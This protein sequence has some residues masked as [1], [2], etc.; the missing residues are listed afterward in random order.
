MSDFSNIDPQSMATQLAGFDVQTLQNQL[1]TQKSKL[2]SQQT[3]LRTL[4][5]ALTEFRTS[6]QNLNKTNAGMLKTSSSV[7]VE[8]M[9]KVTTTSETRKGTYNVFVEQLASSHQLAYNALDEDAVKNATG[10]MKIQVGS[11]SSK[12]ITVDMDN[13]DSLAGLA[14]AI[15]G[16]S[17]NPGVTASLVRT[18]GEV[19]LMLSSDKS[20]A[21]NAL[22][23]SGF[24]EIENSKA[25]TLSEAKDAIAWL[26]EKNNGIQVSSSTNTFTDLIDG[27]T[28][29]LNQAQKD[30][31]TPLRIDV[32]VNTAD[33]T[34]Q[35]NAFVASYNKLLSSLGSLTATGSGSTDRGAFAGDASV[36]NLRRDLNNMLRTAIG[37]QDITQF[38]LSADKDG[39][40]TLDSDKL[41]EK[42]TEDPGKLNALFNGDKGLLKAMDKSM[43]KFLSITGGEIKSREETFRR[44]ETE[45]SDRSDKISTRYDTAY[46]RYLS[47]FTR[48]QSVMQQ[49]NNT[50]NMFGLT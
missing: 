8:N 15:N 21:G 6:M 47:Q 7:S 27:V 23:V 25:V 20:G 28:L 50:A 24:P 41:K 42:L 46:N 1:K 11:D 31:D 38:G 34:A 17:D 2:A 14:K 12:T 48:L 5:S 44:R 40:L 13:V 22:T 10:S 16:V 26:G 45:L 9:V 30:G 33:T 4:K 19:R 32:G 35:V 37:G 39:K 49:M 36:G 29:E 43:D 3:A 18:N